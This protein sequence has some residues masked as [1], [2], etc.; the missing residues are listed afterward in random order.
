MSIL[1]QILLFFL[2]FLLAPIRLLYKKRNG[3]TSNEPRHEIVNDILLGLV[4]EDLRRFAGEKTVT[5][6]VKGYSMRPFIECERDLVK[7][8]YHTDVSVGEAVLA[9][10]EPGHYVLHRVIERN[11]DKLTLQGDGNIRGVE[12]CSV[13]NVCGVVCEYIR[14]NRILLASDPSLQRRIRL[15]RNL[16]PIRRYLLFFY[17]ALV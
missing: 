8:T 5:I 2:R 3:V 17:K 16:R 10:I 1:K 4:S 13:R 6:W 15:W 12:H 11:G 14:P 7:L 9:Q